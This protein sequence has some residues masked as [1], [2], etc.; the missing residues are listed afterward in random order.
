MSEGGNAMK[1][2]GRTRRLIL[3][4]AVCLSAST[5]LARTWIVD[6]CGA[7]DFTGIQSAIG[8]ASNFDEIVVKPG[9]YRESI[10]YRGKRIT[11]R[12]E[13]ANDRHI[14]EKTIIDG[15][16]AG[17]TV[18]FARGE[19]DGAVISGFTIRGGTSSGILCEGIGTCPAIERCIVEANRYGI[20]TKSAAPEVR[21]SIIRGNAKFGV[22]GSS[23]T[24]TSGPAVDLGRIRNCVISGNG[25]H[26][27]CYS[28]NYGKALIDYCTIVGNK[29]CGVFATGNAMEIYV[30]DCIVADHCRYGYERQGQ[31][32]MAI[33]SD[34]DFWSNL[35][36]PYVE[37]DSTVIKSIR[38]NMQLNPLFELPG[39]W[40]DPSKPEVI[41]TPKDCIGVWVEGDYHLQHRSPCIRSGSCGVTPETLTDID[42]DPRVFDECADIGAD[43]WVQGSTGEFDARWG[44]LWIGLARE[45]GAKSPT[46]V[47]YANVAIK[48]NFKMRLHAEVTSLS[49]AGG[50]WTGWFE[51]DNV[52][53]GQDFMVKLWVQG[54]NVNGA[55]TL[56]D[57]TKAL[58]EVS[59]SAE[60]EP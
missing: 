39:Y 45:A 46:Y 48:A 50:D 31:G 1:I 54:T 32:G 34:N 10:D 47:G 26:G 7:G 40:A 44:G 55:N 3:V 51:P 28:G 14:V 30:T 42:G 15:N 18:T 11:I 53:P 16:G 19:G 57:A 35:L 38:D 9:T 13:D 21:L 49:A 23:S 59:V 37:P 25:G 5:C 17:N 22:Y 6:P 41:V 33:L 56:S 24:G 36:G 4:V 52:G 60:L 2:L 43:E 58:A 8:S 27:C 20:E 29:G 12:S